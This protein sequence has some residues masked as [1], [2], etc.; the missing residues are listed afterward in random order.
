MDNSTCK[1]RAAYPAAQN[2]ALRYLF[3]IVTR[4]SIPGSEHI[5][6]RAVLVMLCK[7]A[8]PSRVVTL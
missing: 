5:K 4:Y 6:A 2:S 1:Q 8:K 7:R 3:V